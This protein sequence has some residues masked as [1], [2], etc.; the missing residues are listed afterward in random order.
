VL[1]AIRTGEVGRLVEGE[2]RDCD[3]GGD[4][5]ERDGCARGAG[6]EGRGSPSSLDES[7]D[8]LDFPV[9]RPRRGVA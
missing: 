1:A 7:V 9:K 4:S 8:V 3:A 6:V 5:G 2:R